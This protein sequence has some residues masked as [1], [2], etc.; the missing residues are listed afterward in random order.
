[1]SLSYRKWTVVKKKPYENP[2]VTYFKSMIYEK[3]NCINGIATGK[4]GSGKSWAILSL[5]SQIQ[6]RFK[7]DGNWFFKAGDFMRAITDYYKSNKSEPGKIWVLDEAGVD[8]NNLNF[9]DEINKGLNLF[10]QTARHRNYFFF[11]T[12]PFISFISAGVRKL[13][14]VSIIADG[15]NKKH[16][17]ITMPRILQYNDEMDKFYRKR[18]LVE[19]EGGV[20]PCNKLFVKRPCNRLVNEYEKRKVEFTGDLFEK[21]ATKIEN[22]EE[23]QLNKL[24]SKVPTPFQTKVS[25]CLKQ[26]LTVKETSI[27]LGKVHSRIYDAMKGLKKKG[28]EFIPIR[29]RL[30]KKVV[31]YKV[32]DLRQSLNN[33]AEYMKKQ[34]IT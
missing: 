25:D 18:L 15:W 28:F 1:M 32:I 20:I 30:N 5:V 6:P 14:N 2:W 23:K 22:F 13:M 10:F 3:N 29:E 27:K 17:T 12:V 7:L 11:A 21:T 33:T 24:F 34:A 9:H 26:G 16:K 8:L 19:T 31:A 4:P